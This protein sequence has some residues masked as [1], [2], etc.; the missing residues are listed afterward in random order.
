[1]EPE[2][3]LVYKADTHSQNGDDGIIAA[4]FERIGTTTMVCC[5]FGAWDGIHLSNCRNLILLG[6]SAVMIEGDEY[7]FKDLV[8][9]YTT[10]PL[11]TCVN[12]FVDAELNRLGSI[13]AAHNIGN[14]DLLSIDIDGL[15]YEI[16][17]TLR[18]Y[19]RV[20]CVEVNAGHN[21]ESETR[22]DRELA[23]NN[24]G[25]P[26]QVFVRI[27]DSI[28]Y[29]LVCYTGNAFFV[30]RDVLRKSSLSVLSS[31]QA[32]QHF[33]NHL[34]MPAKEWL[35]LVNCG[36]VTPFFQYGNPYLTHSA[37]GIGKSRAYWLKSKRL[38]LEGARSVAHRLRKITITSG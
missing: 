19:P 38:I 25:Q 30:R 11:V 17:E 15:D 12:R 13:L 32:Y 21:P 10:N 24:V 20:I 36:I 33:L 5:E 28:G 27:A 1:M 14:L 3:L 35:Y 37:L 6:W 31:R 4:I 7:R 22:Q 18:V 29:D 23:K 16:F 2:D 8:S 26:L 9:N 34:P